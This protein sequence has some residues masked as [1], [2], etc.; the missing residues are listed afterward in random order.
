KQALVFGPVMAGTSAEWAFDEARTQELRDTNS[1]SGGR[2]LLDL[3]QAWRSPKVERF[4]DLGGWLLLLT[5]L[6]VLFEALITRMG[7]RM[8]ELAWAG[9]RSMLPKR[10][11]KPAEVV[12]KHRQM[13]GS[14]KPAEY[15]ES[16][17]ATPPEPVKTTDEQRRSRF[18]RAKK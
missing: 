7:W 4:L 17:P 3:A 16:Q 11:A 8:P 9:W 2:E 15:A 6:L 14:A 5:L 10:K 18:A 12:S 13:L 1:A